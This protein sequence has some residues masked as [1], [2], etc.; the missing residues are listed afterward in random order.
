MRVG[1]V[2]RSAEI[3]PVFFDLFRSNK[4]IKINQRII[5]IHIF[6]IP[7][8]PSSRLRI[9]LVVFVWSCAVKH[10]PPARYPLPLKKRVFEQRKQLC[11]FL[12]KEEENEKIY[13]FYLPSLSS[14]GVISYYYCKEKG[15]TLVGRTKYNYIVVNLP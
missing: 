12:R 5:N 2:L 14:F 9:T 6:L 8:A 4:F 11:A 7:A 3:K 1:F 15:K 10:L 13:N